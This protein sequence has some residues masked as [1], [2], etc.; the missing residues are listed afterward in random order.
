MLTIWG[1]FLLG[2]WPTNTLPLP[3]V[4]GGLFRASAGFLLSQETTPWDKAPSRLL[5]LNTFCG[6][7]HYPTIPNGLSVDCPTT[8]HCPHPAVLGWS[9]QSLNLGVFQERSRHHSLC[10]FPSSDTK[11]HLSNISENLPPGTA[12]LIAPNGQTFNQNMQWLS[13]LLASTPIS[14]EVSWHHLTWFEGLTPAPPDQVMTPLRLSNPSLTPFLLI[15]C[16]LLAG[17][18]GTRATK[19]V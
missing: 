3:P 11:S 12:W 17:A 8:A 14:K 4:P 2:P 19:P 9:S 15:L 10:S 5:E 18:M 6:Y 7:P 1:E 16:G 13:P